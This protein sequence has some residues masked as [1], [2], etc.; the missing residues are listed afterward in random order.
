MGRREL[1]CGYASMAKAVR[2]LCNMQGV[3]QLQ[4]AAMD[5]QQ[6]WEELR[7]RLA[8][9]QGDQD[10]LH[11]R[12]RNACQVWLTPGISHASQT[13]SVDKQ[14]KGASRLHC[15]IFQA[16]QLLVL[17]VTWGMSWLLVP[18]CLLA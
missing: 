2:L 13:V 15:V 3:Q 6:Q 1:S 5:Q 14:S 16:H 17:L 4:R 7:E 12:I 11:Q 10:E 9:L 18:V 8:G